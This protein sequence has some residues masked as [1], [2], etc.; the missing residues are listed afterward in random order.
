MCHHLELQ[1]WE[2]LKDMQRR[3]DEEPRVVE[4]AAEPEAFEAEPE[5][6]TERELIRA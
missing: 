4:V 5:P 2:L 3:E 1:D 6:E